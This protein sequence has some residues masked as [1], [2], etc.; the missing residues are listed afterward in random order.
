MVN[1]TEGL[2]TPELIIEQKN[3]FYPYNVLIFLKKGPS[4][5]IV[6]FVVV[7]ILAFLATLRPARWVHAEEVLPSIPLVILIFGK[8]VV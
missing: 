4:V 2:L 7:E 6:P 8:V 5:R 3:N 1:E